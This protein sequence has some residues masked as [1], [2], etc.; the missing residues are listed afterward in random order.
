MKK[1]LTLVFVVIGA[2]AFAQSAYSGKWIKKSYSVDGLWEIVK[3]G[4]VLQL[5]LNED[6]DT[7]KAPDLKIFLSPLAYDK[8]TKYTAVKGSAKVA[9][10]KKYEGKQVFTIP[11]SI[12]ID[13]YK[14]LLIH[15]E[16]YGVLWSVAKLNN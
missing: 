11:A 4:E 2:A 10:L 12:K 14:T 15:C 16:E 7:K 13:D 6:F 9:E 8:V 5:V 3:K 1:L